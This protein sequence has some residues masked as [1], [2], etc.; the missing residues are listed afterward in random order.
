MS[1]LNLLTTDEVAA[2]L[3]S[4]KQTLRRWR[5]TGFGPRFVKVGSKVLYREED[6]AAWLEAR[7]ASSTSGAQPLEA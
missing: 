7:E 2:R 5:C 4:A 1:L 3:R 6:V